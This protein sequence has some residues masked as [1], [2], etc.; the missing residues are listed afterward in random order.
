MKMKTLSCFIE[1]RAF[2]ESAFNDL[3]A[4]YDGRLQILLIQAGAQP[5]ALRFDYSIGNIDAV[6][7]DGKVIPFPKTSEEVR[8]SLPL[9]E[10]I[11]RFLR[12][13]M[14]EMARLADGDNPPD[15]VRLYDLDML[16]NTDG[17]LFDANDRRYLGAIL[18][19][20]DALLERDVVFE[21]CTVPYQKGRSP[22]LYPP[23]F[24]LRRIGERR[25]RVMLSSEATSPDLL[26]ASYREAIA[27]L[28]A[29]GIGCVC[30]REENGWK[31]KTI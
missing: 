26:G 18:D 13:C 29:C 21:V 20:T 16:W 12:A 14:E 19:A 7:F 30:Y 3:C 23:M 9:K 17:T 24:A 4:E 10:D 22:I 27:L 8:A 2:D 25:G 6:C 11:Y 28:R 5:P 31:S 1:D 15:A